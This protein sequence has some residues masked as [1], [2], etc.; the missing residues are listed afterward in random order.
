MVEKW[1]ERMGCIKASWEFP[2]EWD[3]DT[4]GANPMGCNTLESRPV[5]LY[6]ICQAIQHCANHAVLS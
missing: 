4:T 6:I 3:T 5:V 1:V 2:P